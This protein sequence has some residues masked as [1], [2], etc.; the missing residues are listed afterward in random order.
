MR[1]V[2]FES[3]KGTKQMLLRGKGGKAL[4]QAELPQVNV[5]KKTKMAEC[6]HEAIA[7][8]FTQVGFYSTMWLAE[9]KADWVRKV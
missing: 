9:R 6:V 1:Q 7:E 3:R 5:P 4:C 2:H 8:M